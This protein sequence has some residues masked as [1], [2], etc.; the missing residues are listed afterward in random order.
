M[1][2]AP[3]LLACSKWFKER[4]N[5]HMLHHPVGLGDEVEANLGQCGRPGH[6]DLRLELRGN[7]CIDG[8]REGK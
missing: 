4:L 7:L 8:A 2:V 6:D 5:K 3:K 1:A